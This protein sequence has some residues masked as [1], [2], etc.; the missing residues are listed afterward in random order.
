MH[1]SRIQTAVCLLVVGFCLMLAAACVQTNQ[2]REP[3]AA[4]PTPPPVGD[5]PWS[6]A[7]KSPRFVAVAQDGSVLVTY[8]SSGH[9]LVFDPT[10]NVVRE[11]GPRGEGSG[12]FSSPA[13]VAIAPNGE[14]YVVD[15]AENRVH[16]LSAAAVAVGS[17]GAPG[18]GPGEFDQPVGVAVDAGG[19]RLCC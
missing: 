17:W 8:L 19:Q 12:A 3:A 14:I 15:E 5:V 18:E 2:K 6:S 4:V 11:V 1:Q 9:L 7:F 10:G 16:R 13:G